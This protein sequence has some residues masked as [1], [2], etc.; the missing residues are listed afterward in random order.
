[1][2]KHP[3]S[4]DHIATQANH[5]LRGKVLALPEPVRVALLATQFHTGSHYHVHRPAGR[6][7]DG[8]RVPSA[9]FHAFLKPSQQM[10]GHEVACF[11]ISAGSNFWS[12]QFILPRLQFPSAKK[13]RKEISKWVL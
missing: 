1:M 9:A 5:G 3:A 7:H 13:P 8:R 12:F 6:L 4:I 2:R 11:H 10:I